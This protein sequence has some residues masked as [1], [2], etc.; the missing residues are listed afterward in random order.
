MSANRVRLAPTHV[1]T[2]TVPLRL[3]SYDQTLPPLD[4]CLELVRL[5]FPTQVCDDIQLAIG[6]ASAAAPA[7]EEEA[8]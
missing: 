3:V 8:P 5:A 4:A 2:I 1:L 7:T 6:E